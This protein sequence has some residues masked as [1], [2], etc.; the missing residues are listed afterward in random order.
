ML[1]T[2]QK[3]DT[4]NN[5][6]ESTSPEFVPR[7][8][9][10]DSIS[11]KLMATCINLKTQ[12]PNHISCAK[13]QEDEAFALSWSSGWFNKCKVQSPAILKFQRLLTQMHKVHF[14]KNPSVKLSIKLASSW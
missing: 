4:A 7:H 9:M 2:Q 6:Q 12:K 3:T 14:L 5:F 13:R 1:N 11:G 8:I 10:H